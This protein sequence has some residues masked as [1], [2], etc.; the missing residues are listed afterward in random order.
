MSSVFV[1]SWGKSLVLCM[2]FALAVLL[3]NKAVRFVSELKEFFFSFVITERFHIWED[4]FNFLLAFFLRAHLPFA[5]HT[6]FCV[7]LFCLLFHLL[8]VFV[9][10]SFCLLFEKHW[11]KCDL[12]RNLSHARKPVKYENMGNKEHTY[13]CLAVNMWLRFMLVMTLHKCLGGAGSNRVK[14]LIYSRFLFHNQKWFISF[15]CE[16]FL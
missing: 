16:T 15:V 14:A 12:V 2:K 8:I 7:A 4:F 11:K 5:N 13:I 6:T 1:S 3:L 9:F 10:L